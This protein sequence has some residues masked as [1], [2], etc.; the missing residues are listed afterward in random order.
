[1]GLPITL[2]QEV[3]DLLTR[4]ES[5]E[6]SG[7]VANTGTGRRREG[8]GFE[9]LLGEMWAAFGRCAGSQGASL[10]EVTGHGSRHF[11]CLTVAGRTLYVPS[12]GTAAGRSAAS[13]PPQWLQLKFP[14]AELIR[15]FPG[16][17]EAVHRYAPPT[18]RYEGQAYPAMYYRRSTQFDDSIV[19]E[20]DGVLNREDLDR[21][22]IR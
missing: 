16:E 6:A 9:H 18:G 11:A 1:M 22:Q 5:F 12:S 21:I 17:A 14:V 19:L 7:S 15:A 4:I 10:R 8:K 2:S 13:V 20:D 3:L